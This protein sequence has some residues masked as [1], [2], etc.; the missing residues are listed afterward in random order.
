MKPNIS[1]M[2]KMIARE[3]DQEFLKELLSLSCERLSE[4]SVNS[5]EEQLLLICNFVSPE[6]VRILT[7]LANIYY[8]KNDLG[9]ALSLAKKAV[10][11]T[12][13][14]NLNCLLN[15][16]HSTSM[17]GW[18]TKATYSTDWAELSDSLIF[19]L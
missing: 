19:N 1:K 12:E 9:K 11:L 6:N 10:F 2:R 17:A 13:N 4:L 5:L 16:I 15:A 18:S 14:S 8:K 7:K 3:N